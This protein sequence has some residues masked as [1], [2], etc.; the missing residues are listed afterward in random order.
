MVVKKIPKLSI[1]IPR[2][3][4]LKSALV[5]TAGALMLTK[6]SPDEAFGDL[7]SSVQMHQVYD[8]G[9]TFIDLIPR[10]R[11]KQIK[12]EYL[13]AKDDPNFDLEEFVRYHFYAFEHSTPSTYHTDSSQGPREHIRELWKVLE[14]RNR[15]DR[16]SLI[17][18]PYKY[19]VPGGRFSEQYYWDSYFTMLG[20][21][22][23]HRWDLVDSMM[24]N[25]SYMIRK[26]GFIPNSNRTYYLSRSHPPYFSHM[27]KLLAQH[28]N[29]RLTM[30]EYLPYLLSEYR[31]WI[32]GR[33]TLSK[34]EGVAALRRVVR[35]KDGSMLGRHYDN[36]NTP[37]PESLREDVE[38]AKDA[39]GDESEK[40]FLDLRAGAESGW[41]FSSRW[42]A[43]PEEISSIHTT[44]IIPVDLNSLLY[45]LESTIAE[46][47][48]I[49]FQP[50][51]A[52]KF[53][54]LAE[55]R[56][57]AI[58]KHLWDQK[59]QFFVDYDFRKGKQTGRLTLAALYPL[60][61]KIATPEQAKAVA[62]RLE[63]DFLKKGGLMTTLIET[64]QQWDAPNGWAPLHWV[65]I[66]GLRNYGH[67]ALADKI[68]RAWIDTN[69]YVYK[70]QGK[71]VEKYD[72][73]NPHRLGGGG[74]YLLQ[75]GFGWTNGVLAALLNEDEPKR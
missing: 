43:D 53:R 73:V 56:K 30:L 74:E 60:F 23:D 10:K 46:T 16:G 11:V 3:E 65:A 47:Y 48:E 54:R 32:K 26:F 45:H 63:K 75:D 66:Q 42:F 22:A 49:M 58:H 38:A 6:A 29:R 51:L 24:K 41:D 20:L 13:V 15:R 9:K 25:F 33:R 72:V 21:A 67:Y 37:R 8:D 4:A 1:K 39:D 28:K 70:K 17:A 61:V 34:E 35:L 18:I 44:D 68:K 31:F 50:L 69:L 7:F 19:I 27:V 71:M 64:G 57:A 14:R 40:L 36:K 62:R 59:Q 5:S 12:K 52:R 55:Q 2:D